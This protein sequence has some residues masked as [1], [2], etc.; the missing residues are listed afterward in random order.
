MKLVRKRDVKGKYV[1]TIEGGW[2]TKSGVYQKEYVLT[3]PWAKNWYYSKSRAHTRGMEHTLTVEDFRVLWERDNAINMERPSID[4]I[5]PSMG[6]VQGNCRFL[7]LKK[8]ISL[9]N[10]GIKRFRECPN[11]GYKPE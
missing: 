4:R 2:R 3:H 8:N 5:D 11:C 9:D 6:Y 10:K 1:Q 7:E